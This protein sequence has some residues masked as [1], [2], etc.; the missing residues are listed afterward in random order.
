VNFLFVLKEE[1]E[2]WREASIATESCLCDVKIF[3]PKLKTASHSVRH[4]RKDQSNA[5][6]QSRRMQMIVLFIHTVTTHT[7]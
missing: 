6:H 1:S 7:Q 4:V 3:P 2:V 5:A